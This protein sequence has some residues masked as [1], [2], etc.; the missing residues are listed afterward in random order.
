MAW[1]TCQKVTE[2]TENKVLRKTPYASA[3]KKSFAE[4]ASAGH[5]SH[6]HRHATPLVERASR[7]VSALPPAISGLRGHDKT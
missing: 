2:V 1:N 5:F 4:N 6:Q 7:Y 3:Y